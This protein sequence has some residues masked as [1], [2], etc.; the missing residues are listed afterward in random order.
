MSKSVYKTCEPSIVLEKFSNLIQLL[1]DGNGTVTGALQW[2]LLLFLC[3]GLQLLHNSLDAY[4][5]IEDKISTKRYI[6]ERIIECTCKASYQDL[7]SNEV[8]REKIAFVESY[9][10]EKV[11]ESMQG[12]LRLIQY[13]ITAV[14]I[15]YVLAKVHI[16]I[17]ILLLITS[18]PAAIL[19]LHQKDETYRSSLKWMKEG[20]WV[21]HEFF[22]CCGT[23]TLNEVRHLQIF[24]YL[25]EKWKNYAEEYKKKKKDLTKKHVLYNS[26]ADVLR[27]IVS[28]FVLLIV[29][30]EIY[31]NPEIGVGVF[32]LVIHASSQLQNVTS[33]IVVTAIQ[34]YTDINFMGDFFELEDFYVQEDQNGR[35]EDICSDGCGIR[36]SNVSFHY[37]KME[38]DVLKNISLTIHS[39][40][41]VAIVGE[42]GSGKTTFVNLLCGLYAPQEGNIYMNEKNVSG[43][44]EAVRDHMA[45]VFQD[46]GRYDESVRRNIVVSDTSNERDDEYLFRLLKI[47]GMDE[48]V[49]QMKKGL[50]E[51]IGVFHEEGKNLSGGQ[52]QKIALARALNKANA[53]IMILDEPTAAMDPIAEA[54]LYQNFAQVTGNRTVLFI[55]HRLGVTKL[56]DRIIVFKNGRIVEDGS[57]QEL[58][59]QDKIFA[60]MYHTQAQWYV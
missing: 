36:F 9:A 17:V 37:P 4:F 50:D 40:E 21:I 16:F 53:G 15:T 13:L 14:S 20:V 12:I 2:L 47:V 34:L 11:A 55:S 29:A 19:T 7:E 33:R 60:E 6:K 22:M 3:Y 41:K 51:G 48:A 32:M 35:R 43:K 8:F 24:E 1:A 44:L 54:E 38:K 49:K 5:L 42:N 27:N 57:F 10:G 28:I 59:E 39:G 30:Y 52:W 45:V 23:E 26:I 56:V 25:K 31:C 46:F 58:M 18:I